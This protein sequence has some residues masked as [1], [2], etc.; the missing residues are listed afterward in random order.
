MRN[1]LLGVL[2]MIFVGI[3]GLIAYQAGRQTSQKGNLPEPTNSIEKPLS[4]TSSQKLVG[5]DRD[6]HGCIGSAGYTWCEEKQKCLRSWEESCSTTA[7]PTIDETQILKN[8][9]KQALVAKHG[10]S[11]NELTITV[12][13]IQGNYASGGAAATGGGGMWFAAKVNG[14]WQLVWDGNGVIFCSALQKYPDFPNTLIPE[15]FDE[16]SQKSIKR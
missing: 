10:Q 14:I 13:T 6:E 5:N 1:F 4:P 16:T 11:A 2:F 7:L 8:A 15:C 12:S 3:V 9:V